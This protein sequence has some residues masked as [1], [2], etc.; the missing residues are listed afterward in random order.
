MP[1]VW[2]IFLVRQ[3]GGMLRQ[4]RSKCPRLRAEGRGVK[5]AAAVRAGVVGLNRPVC[6]LLKRVPGY[7]FG[8]KTMIRPASGRARTRRKRRVVGQWGGRSRRGRR[9]C[10]RPARRTFSRC[11]GQRQATLPSCADAGGGLRQI[12]RQ[13]ATTSEL[14]SLMGSP[15]TASVWLPSQNGRPKHAW[16]PS[17]K[18]STHCRATKRHTGWSRGRSQD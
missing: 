4:R 17:R 15:A 6:P 9:S 3:V 13:L 7:L 14:T 18:A 8:E 2:H 5:N 10:L 12:L 16:D 11:T 1:T